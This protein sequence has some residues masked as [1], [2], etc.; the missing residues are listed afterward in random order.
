MEITARLSGLRDILRDSL[1]FLP[2]VAVVTAAGLGVILAEIQVADDEILSRWIFAAGAEGARAVLQV[3][4]G[5]FMTVLSVTFSLTV[6]ALVN[7]SNQYSPRVLTTFLRDRG[8]QVVLAVFLANFTYSIVVLRTVQTV[9]DDSLG[10]PRLAVTVAALLAFS[11]LAALVYFIHH[12][13]QSLRVESILGGVGADTLAAIK[14]LPPED[15]VHSAEGFPET[16]AD[17][18]RLS[19]RTSGVV[20]AYHP[21]RL[22]RFARDNQ[23]LFAFR[24]HAGEHVTAG[25][26]LAFAWSA[27][28]E[29]DLDHTKLAWVANNAVQVGNERTLVQDVAFGVRQLADI[30]LRALSPSVNDPTTATDAL[31]RLGAVLGA[32]APLPLGAW[33]S[34]D[35]DGT[36]R[37]LVPAPEFANYL[38]IVVPQLLIHG[39]TDPAAMSAL[40]HLLEDIGTLTEDPAR[41]EVVIAHIRAC[42]EMAASDLVGETARSMVA[43]AVTRA[44]D[45]LASAPVRPALSH[46]G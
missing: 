8:Q 35:E 26:P 34:R 27:N 19:A 40:V 16:P 23:V 17:A 1:W 9:G 3:I 41:R 36:P 39:S 38:E 37:V 6:V 42:S 15:D 7:A 28:G 18:V 43:Q 11:G 4:A 10:V 31:G 24:H 21:G 45:A 32:L 12:I 2:T 5:S 22:S 44:L 46:T 33:S 13:T 30:A 14:R 29:R 25:T 20:Q